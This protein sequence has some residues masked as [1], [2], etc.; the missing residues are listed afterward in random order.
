MRMSAHVAGQEVEVDM[1]N[2]TLTDVE[3]G[4]VYKL[5]PLGEVRGRQEINTHYTHS[6]PSTCMIPCPPNKPMPCRSC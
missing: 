6:A 4:R 1:E 2:D 3:S 5:K